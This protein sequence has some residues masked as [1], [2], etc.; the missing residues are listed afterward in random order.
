MHFGA[1]SFLLKNLSKKSELLFNILYN[2]S[3][4]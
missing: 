3:K 4:K 1:F 2:E